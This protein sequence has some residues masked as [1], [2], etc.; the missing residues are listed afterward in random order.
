MD[1][2]VFGGREFYAA[3][4]FI[5][6]VLVLAFKLLNPTPVQ[7]LVEGNT[8]IM[9]QVP[10]LFTYT[11]VLIIGGAL[12]CMTASVCYLVMHDSSSVRTAAAA[13]PAS[14]APGDVLLEE[15]RQ[16][17]EDVSKTLKNDEQKVYKTI[18]DEGIIN[19]SELVNR[20]GLSKSNVSRA[21]YGLESR[22]LVE[23][24]RRGMGNVVLLK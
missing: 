9:S 11:D 4:L 23:R 19:Q 21:L 16:R 8:V 12:I 15:R 20:T 22:G 17:W 3:A 6:S 18:I 5:A 2:R 24:R 10:G 7:L 1:R 14:P 13:N